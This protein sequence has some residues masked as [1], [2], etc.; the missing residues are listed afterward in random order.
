MK[1]S[2][3]LEI[4]ISLEN[5]NTKYL[6]S[7][8]TINNQNIKQANKTDLVTFGR[9]K[10][11]IKPGDKIYKI[12]DKNL[13]TLALNSYNKEN[14]KNPLYCKLEIYSNKK[15]KV[16][17]KCLNFEVESKFL[18]DF[19]PQKAQNAPVT[20]EKVKEQFNKT[21][22]TPFE[23]SNIE[24]DMEDNIFIPTSVL[25][26]IRRTAISNIEEKILNS[27]KRV[28]NFKEFEIK[29]EKLKTIA[30]KKTL[31]LNTLNHKFDYSKLKKVHRIYIPL[32]FFL[33]K[34]YSFAI[35]TLSKISNIYIYMPTIIKDR[36]FDIIKNAVNNAVENYNI[37]GFVISE[38]SSLEFLKIFNIEIIANYNFNVY[39]SFTV[40]KLKSLGFS[41]ITLSPELDKS[42][43]D[44]INLKEKEVIVYGKIPLMTT[45]YCLLGKTNRCYKD[46]KHLCLEDKKF[47]LKDRYNFKFRIIPDNLQTLNI[48]YN[49]RNI[50]VPN[51]NALYYRYDILDESIE[52]INDLLK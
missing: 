20:K 1:I 39:N 44:N 25:N 35:N 31:L 47:Y 23:F 22:D 16:Y 24:I 40:N 9:M 37:S 49:S 17:I 45:S 6:V 41:A 2:F 4:G 15:I 29:N 32:K 33:D 12:T 10:G 21:Q 52:Q 51:V 7:E 34:K 30:T 26:N 11:N 5:E 27:F 14:I 38:F 46:C 19:I 3:Q 36:Y 18:Y 50:S 42:D 8:L 28:S 13:S 43:F 48:I